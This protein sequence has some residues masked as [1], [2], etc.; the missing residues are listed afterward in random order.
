V[1]TKT[2]VEQSG[3]FNSL[4]NISW[5]TVLNLTCQG[6]GSKKNLYSS[7]RLIMMYL[8]RMDQDE[9]VLGLRPINSGSQSGMVR[10]RSSGK[11]F[12]HSV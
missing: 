9:F 4:C 10:P 8:R 3:K 11:H 1:K 7:D 12:D 6:C 5:S 2:W